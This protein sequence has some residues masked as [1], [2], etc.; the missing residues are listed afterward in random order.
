MAMF[1]KI[2]MK[3]ICKLWKFRTV[4]KRPFVFFYN[5]IENF[6]SCTQMEISISHKEIR[7]LTFITNLVLFLCF[8]Y[9]VSKWKTKLEILLNF[10]VQIFH[11]TGCKNIDYRK[12]VTNLYHS[13][14]KPVVYCRK[15]CCKK[16]SPHQKP[17]QK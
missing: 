3:W 17:L 16:V 9:F 13:F 1:I 4:P 6:D 10:G 12:C 2:A 11:K 15:N 8:W 7:N 5:E 14:L